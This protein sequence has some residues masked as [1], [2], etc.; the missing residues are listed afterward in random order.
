MESDDESI[1]LEKRDK[2]NVDVLLKNVWLYQ[3]VTQTFVQRNVA[4]KNDKFYYIY[5]EENVNLQ[6]QKTINA[7]NQWMIPGLIDAHMHIESSMTTPTIFSK[8]VV[9]YGV[10]TVIA[11]AHEMANV[12][13]LEGLKAFMAAE[14]EL[15][16]FH[17]IPFFGSFDHSRIRNNWWDYRLSR[18]SRITQRTKS[19]LFRGSHEF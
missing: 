15:D 16:I 11:D 9:R 13:G 5:E 10:T 17:A 8:A 19:D 3:T 18:S 7:E 2:M 6:P 1:V 4:I 12:F 14:T